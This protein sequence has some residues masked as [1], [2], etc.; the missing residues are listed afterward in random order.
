M[1]RLFL[2][3]AVAAIAGCASTGADLVPG[4]STTADVEREMGK[5]AERIGAAGGDTVWYYPR[6]LARTTYAVRIGANGVV[7]DVSQV[8]TQANLAKLQI[9]KST[10]E[11]VKAILGP[12]FS[13][14]Q[15]PRVQREGW[16]YYMFQ[17]T[18]PK[19]TYVQFDPSGRVS[20]VMQIDDPFYQSRGAGHAS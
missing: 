1:N 16:E 14:Y 20:E 13:V 7:R 11:D 2:I 8:L 5:P 18:R 12:P 15:L 19:V 3:V 6:G 17:D 9:G 4:K 10:K